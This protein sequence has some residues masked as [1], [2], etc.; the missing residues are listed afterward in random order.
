M[1][2]LLK[3]FKMTTPRGVTDTLNIWPSRTSYLMD[4]N[5]VIQGLLPHQ[6]MYFNFLRRAKIIIMIKI[7]RIGKRLSYVINMARRETLGPFVQIQRGIKQMTNKS[8]SITRRSHMKKL[9]DKNVGQGK[10]VRFLQNTDNEASGNDDHAFARF[11]FCNVGYRHELYLRNMLI[12][13]NKS[14]FDNFCNNSRVT[15]VST[16]YQ[17]MTVKQN[18][19][20][21]KNTH[22]YYTEGYIEV[23]F[24][25]RSITNIL[26]LNNVE[27]KFRYTYESKN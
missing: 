16:T 8:P 13:Y 5:T 1:T 3:N 20:T 17:S 18:V 25:E 26:V 10:S 22:K 6:Q 24:D 15:I 21:I 19:V 14:T 12:L 7:I 11:G 2:G 23:W 9:R 4:K 27:S